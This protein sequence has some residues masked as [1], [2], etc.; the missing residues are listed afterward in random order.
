MQN[1]KGGIER[2]RYIVRSFHVD[3]KERLNNNEI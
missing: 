3:G 1:G 2:R